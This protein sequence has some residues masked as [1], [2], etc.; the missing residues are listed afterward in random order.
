MG[1]A[2]TKLRSIDIERSTPKFLKNIWSVCKE[3]GFFK[4]LLTSV[5]VALYQFAFLRI[6]IGIS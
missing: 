5:P 4:N 1:S 2:Y 6:Q 3:R